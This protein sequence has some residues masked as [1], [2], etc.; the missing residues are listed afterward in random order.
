MTS[1]PTSLSKSETIYDDRHSSFVY[2]SSWQDI[3]KK[4][5]YNG[6]YKLTTEN[7]ANV[8]FAFA[9]QSFSVLYKG[10]PAFRKMDVYVDNTLVGT[11]NQKASGSS[12]QLRWDY[13][14][15]LTSGNHTLKL[16]FITENTSGGT[17]GS[18]DA[19]IVR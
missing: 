4:P 8:T 5:A 19:V 16:V 17:N 2:S 6:S 15:Q 7:G 18:V 11:I 13:S 1:T 10:G 3:T 9:G 14:G 12:F